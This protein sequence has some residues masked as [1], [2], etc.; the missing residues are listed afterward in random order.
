[1]KKCIAPVIGIIRYTSKSETIIYTYTGQ[2][3]YDVGYGNIQSHS[4]EPITTIFPPLPP[5][6]KPIFKAKSI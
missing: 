5:Y 6:Y 4:I 1:M 2:I 3:I